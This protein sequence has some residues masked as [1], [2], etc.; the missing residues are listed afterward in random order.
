MP[1]P[2]S[3]NNTESTLFA[4]GLMELAQASAGLADLSNLWKQN[5]GRIDQIKTEDPALFKALQ[6]SFAEIKQQHSAK[7]G[8]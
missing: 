6:K 4:E 8:D 3:R 1:K 2:V 5:Q 7:I